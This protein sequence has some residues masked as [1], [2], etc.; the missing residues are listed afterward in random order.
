MGLALSISYDSSQALTCAWLHGL[1]PDQQAFAREQVKE[2]VALTTHPLLLPAIL[3]GWG[4]ELIESRLTSLFQLLLQIELGGGKLS[5]KS[6]DGDR[7]YYLETQR[8][9]LT[10]FSHS[11]IQQATWN[12]FYL[13]TALTSIE[14]LLS[15]MAIIELRT[16]ELLRQKIEAGSGILTA[17]L[18]FLSLKC[19]TMLCDTDQI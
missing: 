11:A 9:V 3:A 15:Q 13:K 2:L 17:R 19:E 8:E 18:R 4:N 5:V 10:D 6:M 14:G 12:R 1:S 16:P 7:R